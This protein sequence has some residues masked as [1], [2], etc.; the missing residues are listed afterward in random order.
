LIA[1]EN[2]KPQTFLTKPYDYKDHEFFTQRL[3]S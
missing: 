1:V 2:D 3:V